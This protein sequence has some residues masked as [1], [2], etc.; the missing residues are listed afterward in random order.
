VLSGPGLG[1]DPPFAH[2]ARK[3]NL[4]KRVVD[5]V[6]PGVAEILTFEVDRRPPRCCVSRSA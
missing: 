6:G 2:P 5:L 1:N 4:A 3:Q